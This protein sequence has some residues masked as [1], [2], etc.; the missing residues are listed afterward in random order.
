MSAV[1]AATFN[2]AISTG[3]H[4]Q[5]DTLCESTGFLVLTLDSHGIM[6]RWPDVRGTSEGCRQT[7]SKSQ[8]RCAFSIGYQCEFLHVCALTGLDLISLLSTYVMLNWRHLLELT[9]SFR[10]AG[11]EVSTLNVRHHVSVYIQAVSDDFAS[12]IQNRAFQQVTPGT[13]ELLPHPFGL[14]HFCS[15]HTRNLRCSQFLGGAER[16]FSNLRRQVQRPRF[17]GSTQRPIFSSQRRH[18]RQCWVHEHWFL[19]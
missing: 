12:V 14:W 1:K 7:S 8:V 4:A 18:Y 16:R 5:P 9:S 6:N 3:G 19:G 17:C 10:R 15:R 11:T 2:V 13:Y